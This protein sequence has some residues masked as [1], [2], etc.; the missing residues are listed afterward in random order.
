MITKTDIEKLRN[1]HSVAIGE[2]NIL[3]NR[4]NLAVTELESNELTVLNCSKARAIIQVVAKE[5]QETVEERISNLV[6]LALSS[7]FPDPYEFKLRFVLRRNKTEADL[8]FIKRGNEGN[9]IDVGGG[10]V[11]DVTSF[12][13]RVAVWSIKPTNNVFIQDEPFHFLSRNLQAKCSQMIKMI[14]QKVINGKRLQFIIV[15]HIPEITESADRVFNIIN[16]NGISNIV[17]L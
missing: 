12:A 5:T 8:I 15:S 7:V 4:L 1:K 6:S 17:T 16:K 3:E 11:L 14:N 10:G 9:P 13:L 2:R